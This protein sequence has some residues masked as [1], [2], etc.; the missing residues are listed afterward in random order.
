[1]FA[2]LGEITDLVRDQWFWLYLVRLLCKQLSV[3]TRDLTV[4]TTVIRAGRT[5]QK[6]VHP[7][8]VMV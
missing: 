8:V 7:V 5:A 2:G 1:M 4:G 6:A 3:Q